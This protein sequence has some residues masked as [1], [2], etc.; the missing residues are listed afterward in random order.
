M[1]PVNTPILQICY[2]VTSTCWSLTPRQLACCATLMRRVLWGE[3]RIQKVFLFLFIKVTW[4][5]LAHYWNIINRQP[6]EQT[7]IQPE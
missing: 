6:S 4:E 1:A 7:I 3:H 2:S 5:S